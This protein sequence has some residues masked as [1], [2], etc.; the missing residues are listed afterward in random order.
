M[1]LQILRDH[2]KQVA[3]RDRADGLAARIK[4][5]HDWDI[6]DRKNHTQVVLGAIDRGT[7]V[8]A[9]AF[10]VG[11]QSESK[12][13]AMDQ[14]LEEIALPRSAS[15]LASMAKLDSV[16]S[17]ADI[18]HVLLEM[19]QDFDALEKYAHESVH[20]LNNLIARGEARAKLAAL[21][22]E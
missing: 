6:L 11:K 20:R 4:Q 14:R 19:R 5:Q 12:L 10:E 13:Q 21:E 8:A 7:Q 16:V 18:A 2:K 15:I 22:K 1:V 9:N 17:P 3:A